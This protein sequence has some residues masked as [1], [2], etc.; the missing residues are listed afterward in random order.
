MSCK[1]ATQ[2]ISA[3]PV[4]LEHLFRYINKDI[5]ETI[6]H[7][8]INPCFYCTV[9]N[10]PENVNCWMRF[11][12]GRMVNVE[13]DDRLQM[14]P[15]FFGT[16]IP[17]LRELL[18]KLY[19]KEFI[20]MDIKCGFFPLVELYNYD[21]TDA[22]LY[23]IGSNKV[24][25]YDFTSIVSGELTRVDKPYCAPRVHAMNSKK[26]IGMYPSL[27][28]SPSEFYNHQVCKRRIHFIRIDDPLVN[29][30][31]LEQLFKKMDF[32]REDFLNEYRQV[33]YDNRN[34]FGRIF[35]KLRNPK[36]T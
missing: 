24:N 15:I 22:K 19:K 27:N 36:G 1:C 6:L 13:E 34:D 23:V 11:F 7:E 17:F 29:E 30:I 5:V 16:G 32:Y 31:E 20:N 10:T 18:R 35:L 21:A 33:M 3:S 28:D 25:P 12:L 14:I 8:Y 9:L 2:K 4:L 26:F